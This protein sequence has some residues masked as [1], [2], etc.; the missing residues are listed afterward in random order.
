MSEKCLPPHTA[1]LYSKNWVCKGIPIFLT[2]SSKHRLCV[3]TI[4]VLSLFNDFFIFRLIFCTLIHKYVF[5][6][7]EI[8]YTTYFLVGETLDSVSTVFKEI[9]QHPPHTLFAVCNWSIG[10]PR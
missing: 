2:L 6:M 5:V 7:L 4:Y 10:H 9:A 8:T 1:L 3:P